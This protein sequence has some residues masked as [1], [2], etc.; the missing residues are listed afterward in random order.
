VGTTFGNQGTF[1]TEVALVPTATVVLNPITFITASTAKAKA[2]ITRIDGYVVTA[3]GIIYD[4]YPITHLS[5]GITKEWISG[6]A[7]D[8]DL[9]NLSPNTLY[10]VR[11]FVDNIFGPEITFTTKAI[12]PSATIVLNSITEI[13]KTNAWA[14]ATIAINNGYVITSAGIIY[15]TSAITALTD[16][17]KKEWV[18]GNTFAPTLDNLTPGTLYYVRPYLDGVLGNQLTFTTLADDTP[19]V[20]VELDPITNITKNT[21]SVTAKIKAL[22]GYAVTTGGIR[23]STT[24]INAITDGSPGG[25]WTAGDKITAEIASLTAETLYYVRPFVNNVLGLQKTFTTLAA[26][27]TNPAITLTKTKV[28]ENKYTI[29]IA[30]TSTPESK[31][32]IYSKKTNPII[33]NGTLV[34]YTTNT[35]DIVFYET[36]TYYIKAWMIV[37]GVKYYSAQTEVT[38][39]TVLNPSGFP[40]N[41]YMGMEW[42]M[43]TQTWVWNGEGWAK[44]AASGAPEQEVVASPVEQPAIIN[45]YNIELENFEEG[46]Y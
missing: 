32:I 44:K 46:N 41:P 3:A 2:L 21:A 38:I 10:Y 24:A 37:G 40:M 39:T 26:G 6:D 7:I 17:T 1:T 33:G 23:Y 16:G 18:A 8:A 27:V 9:T 25:T 19:S 35:Q 4:R 34:N 14:M 29:G 42:T 15:S 12:V 45:E 13:K 43:G 5:N 31:G 22:G 30:T 28:Q 36:T 11:P 20:T